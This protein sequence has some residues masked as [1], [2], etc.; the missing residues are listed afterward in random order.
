MQ[1]EN[2]V[3]SAVKKLEREKE[4]RTC[5]GRLFHTMGA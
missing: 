4:E 1:G 2:T 5:T 3:L